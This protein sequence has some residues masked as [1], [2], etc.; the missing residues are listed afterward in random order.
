MKGARSFPQMLY[1]VYKEY[2]AFE[3]NLSKKWYVELQQ[4]FCK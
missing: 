2:I 3:K 4:N 1:S